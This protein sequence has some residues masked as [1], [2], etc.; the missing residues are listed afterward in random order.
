M[1]VPNGAVVYRGPSRIDG[2]PLVVV[3]TGIAGQSRNPKTGP[4]AQSWILREDVSPH[5][6]ARDGR[7]ESIC[8]SCPHRLDPE[9]G[10]RTCYVRPQEAPL[11][12]WRALGRGLYPDQKPSLVGWLLSVYGTG[13]RV[14]SYGDPMAVPMRVWMPMVRRA[15]LVTGYTHQA[16][17]FRGS[18]AWSRFVM[19]SADSEG[20]ALELQGRGFRTFR[21]G[22]EP[23]PGE[24]F[25]PATEEGGA[26]ATC[27][28]CGLCSGAL[29]EGAKSIV[30]RPHGIGAKAIEGRLAAER[31]WK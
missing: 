2:A 7:D 8:G 4:M 20:E 24:I 10:I 9:T 6:A 29:R 22:L 31:T 23:G 19:A 12:I 1:S 28:T 25:C 5:V 16:D 3:V 13:I 30:V 27:E 14:G 26:K 18:E 11:T 17:R 15:R 21:I